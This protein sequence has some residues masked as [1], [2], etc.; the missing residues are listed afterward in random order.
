MGLSPDKFEDIKDFAVYIT[1]PHIDRDET[2]IIVQ[3]LST[4]RDTPPPRH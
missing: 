1:T 4:V 2:V 3:V